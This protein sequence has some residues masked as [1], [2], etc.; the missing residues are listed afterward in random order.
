M[1]RPTVKQVDEEVLTWR[2]AMYELH[3]EIEKLDQEN[4]LLRR[5]LGDPL[6]SDV[7]PDSL[8]ESEIEIKQPWENP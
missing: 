8:E 1:S 7:S 2:H 5:R 6:T 3:R 4:D